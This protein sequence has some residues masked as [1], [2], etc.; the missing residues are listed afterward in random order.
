MGVVY[1]ARDT[2][3]DR[4]VAIKVLPEHVA[5]DPDVRQRFEREARAIAALNHPHICV[6]H[7]IGRAAPLP[8]PSPLGGEGARS[9]GEGAVDFLVMEYLEGETL[10]ER[11]AGTAGS[12]DPGLPLNEALRYAIQIADALDKAHRQ[13][14]VHR[15]LK[16]GNIM[17]TKSG[18]KLLDF[19]LAKL[20]PASVAQGFSPASGASA[21]PTVSTPLTAAGSILGTFQYM[22]P[23]Q[24]DGQEADTRTDLFAF[25]A[26]L[27]EMVTGRRAFE[28]K[29]HASLV[30][31][32]MSFQP[33]PIAT[34]QPL[35]PPGVDRVVGMCLAKDPDDRL[36]NAHD[37]LLHLE[38]VAEGGSQAG[39]A[40]PVATR[41][42]NR[43]LIWSAATLLIGAVSASVGVW[44]LMRPEPSTV[45]RFPIPLAAGDNFNFTRR[46]V[47]A[48]SP[49]GRHVVY[50]ANQG[51]YLRP[52]DQLAATLVR[53]TEEG[54]GRNPFFSP[55]GQWIGFW[56]GGQLKKVGLG[57]GAPVTLGAADNP[58]GV[59]WD[60]NDTILFGQ[61]P[62]GIWKV[63][64]AGGTPEVLI[65]VEEGE[66]AH[67][68]QLLPGDEWVLFTFRPKGA[69]SW[70]DAQIVVQSLETGERRV[71]ISGGR[72]ARYMPSGHLV[73]A[74][75]GV[76][77]AVPFDVGAVRVTGG[78]VSLIEGVGDSG[79]GSGAVHYGVAREGTLI[80]A[81]A[82]AAA[83]RT[84]VWVDRQGREE[85]INTQPRPYFT[86]RISPDGARVAVRIEDGD[87]DVWIYEVARGI[88]E[89]LTFDPG[90]DSQAVWSPD[91]T[92]LAY[93]AAGRDGGPGI[94]WRAADGTG[95][96]QRLTAGGLHVPASWSPE[97]RRL[98]FTDVTGTVAGTGTPDI[99]VVELDGSRAPQAL[100]ATRATEGEP[101]ISPDGR[102]LAFETNETGQDEIVVRPFPNVDGGRWRIST[103]G[104]VNPLWAGDGRTLF[105][106]QDQAIMAV[107]VRAGLPSAWGTP[108]R[109]FQVQQG[110][111]LFQ[112]GPA[113]V[114]VAPDGQRF[115]MIKE[116]GAGQTP[117]PPQLIAVLNWLEELKARVPT[118]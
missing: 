112:S 38:W 96:V 74:L 12:K 75:E 103:E 32:I 60:A 94:H 2:R 55:D 7:D 42:K 77:L 58:Y 50:Q 23:E 79:S 105:Y 65:A 117:A 104:G 66:Q 89:R 16:P 52:I 93:H 48:I 14:I 82:G 109:L 68:P 45:A 90:R 83:A 29:S 88:L 44:A 34:L 56:A 118:N 4:A 78:A 64:G 17:L 30:S 71:L 110:Q 106:R 49:D 57:G 6:L 116:G 108:E 69:S 87:D 114:D 102:W 36:Q 21:V 81:A 73:Y 26:V 8:Q 53:G 46:H 40:A 33:P 25:G 59:S 11:L 98:V 61:G 80:Y 67:G 3:L 28:G 22:A 47:V 24:L 41:R 97:G 20:R 37:L 85:A 95:D 107:A 91:G 19:G 5:S 39:V 35:T 15:D 101:R 115:L 62:K 63:P 92:R 113:H 10:A 27:Y 72:D 1:R 13:G 100:I 84:L 70:D 111:Y 99:A 54:G 31:A 9:A 43:A 18:A 76:L 86:P 51:L